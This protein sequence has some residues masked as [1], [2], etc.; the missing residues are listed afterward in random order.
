M[1]QEVKT[2]FPIRKRKKNTR[3]K[4]HKGWIV[5]GILASVLI[6]ELAVAL[7]LFG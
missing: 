6:V 5:I 3:R 2:K 7:L 4:L 1:F